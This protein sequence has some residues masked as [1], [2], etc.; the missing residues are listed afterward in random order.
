MKMILFCNTFYKYFVCDNG[1]VFWPIVVGF[2]CDQIV[3]YQDC[4]LSIPCLKMLLAPYVAENNLLLGFR[5]V[6][7]T[8]AS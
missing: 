4:I 6:F 7:I 3:I 1:M 8:L 5:S 2:F